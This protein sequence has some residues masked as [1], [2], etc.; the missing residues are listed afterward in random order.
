V[1]DVLKFLKE[2]GTYYL[3]TVDAD[4]NPQVRP[5]G[6]ITKFEDALYI[7]TGNVKDCFKQMV[8]HSRIAISAMSSSGGE[9][10]RIEADAVQD[11]RREAREALLNDYPHLRGLY[12]EDDGNCEAVKLTNVKATFCSFTAEPRTVE[13]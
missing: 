3:A 8:A 9:W 11:D 2:C 5:F 6:T 4:G 7:Q 1:D 10:I 12:S 13:F